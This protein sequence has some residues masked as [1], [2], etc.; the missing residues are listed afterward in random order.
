MIAAKA[1]NTKHFTFA[2][3]GTSFVYLIQNILR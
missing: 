2:F 3:V 1:Q